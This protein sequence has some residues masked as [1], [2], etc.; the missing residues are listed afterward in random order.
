[1]RRCLG[2]GSLLGC[3]LGASPVHAAE[4]VE[5]TDELAV[6]GVRSADEE[7][8]ERWHR[9][10]EP[11]REIEQREQRRAWLGVVTAGLGA[12]GFVALAIGSES[13]PR[14]G[15]GDTQSALLTSASGLGVLG[16]VGSLLVA[17]DYA[18]ELLLGSLFTALGNMQMSIALSDGSNSLAYLAGASAAGLY[19]SAGLVVLNGVMRPRPI[20]RLRAAGRR[21]RG[22]KPDEAEIAR[23]EADLE[24]YERPIPP[25]ITYGPIVLAG[26]ATTTWAI[27]EGIQRRSIG[28]GVVGGISGLMF[29]NLGIMLAIHDSWSPSEE[30]RATAPA[31]SAQWS[32]SPGPGDRGG[33]SIVGQF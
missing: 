14:L 10:E 27:T 19:T 25:W 3:Q 24:Q 13:G 9:L 6:A 28:H 20:A 1:M 26:A 4:P 30:Y 32:L 29:V 7:L 5:G 18:T 17:E 23:V 11:L 22:V 33:M 16:G 8:I 2:V 21:A 12:V 31:R 15:F